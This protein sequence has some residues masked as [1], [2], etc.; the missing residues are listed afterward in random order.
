[1]K[2]HLFFG[3]VMILG[4]LLFLIGGC[5]RVPQPSS[6]KFSSQHKMQ[7]AHHWNLLAADVAARI[8]DELLR[9]EYLHTPVYVRNLCTDANKKSDCVNTPFAQGFSDLLTTQL[10]DFGVPTLAQ[11]AADALVV[12]N[13][14]QVIYHRSGRIRRLWPGALTTL[15][16]GIIALYDAPWKVQALAAS[17][18]ADIG[19]GAE[20]INGHYEIIISTSIVD[21]NR[22][23]MRK[24]DI[25][26]INDLDYRHYRQTIPLPVSDIKLTTSA[27]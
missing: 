13:K 9:Q 7:A 10:V 27:F 16:G 6:Y 26:Y 25:Y 18:L 3:P 12:D 11:P 19:G 2:R 4:I 20:I 21:D 5:A 1:M 22:F 14:V 8:N 23:I 24:S 17:A 15:T